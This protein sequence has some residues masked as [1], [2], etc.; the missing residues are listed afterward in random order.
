MSRL[1][2]YLSLHFT[3]YTQSLQHCHPRH[4]RRL[5]AAAS[6]FPL[7]ASRRQPLCHDRSRAGLR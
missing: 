7:M 2:A 5:S 1:L 3:N 6:R 4:K